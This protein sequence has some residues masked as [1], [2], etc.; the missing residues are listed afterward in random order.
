MKKNVGSRILGFWFNNKK[1]L[2]IVTMY[3]PHPV[4]EVSK[5]QSRCKFKSTR[6]NTKV[7]FLYKE[8]IL[9]CFMI[10]RKT[11]SAMAVCTLMD[12]QLTHYWD[13]MFGQLLFSTY[14]RMTTEDK[15]NL[16]NTVIL[17]SVNASHTCG[18]YRWLIWLWWNMWKNM[19]TLPKLPC[20]TSKRV[21]PS[22]KNAGFCLE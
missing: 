7:L 1:Q 8:A 20:F 13:Q 15:W 3:H 19:V 16:V 11:M 9:N 12:Y 22:T 18:D 2:Y 6:P 10:N 17:P 5:R 21:E 14:F 4:P